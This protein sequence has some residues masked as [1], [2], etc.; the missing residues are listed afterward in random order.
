MRSRACVAAL[1]LML[2]VLCACGQTEEISPTYG[3]EQ[4]YIHTTPEETIPA[5]EP[6]EAYVEVWRE[7]EISRIP[8]EIIHGTVGDYTIAMD[9]EYFTFTAHETVDMFGYDSWPGE[10]PVYFAISRYESAYD[11]AQFAADMLDQ[12][13]AD[14]A[15]WDPDALTVGQYSATALYL[16]SSL[17]APDYNR[18]IFLIDCGGERYLI[19]TE[20]CLEMYE[21]LYPIM[22]A[23]FDTFT[24]G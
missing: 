2:L 24:C 3:T 15:S 21:G 9:P 4:N 20:F 17:D 8:V 11:P 5:T 16:N 14:Y 19:E 7:G 10:Q 23:L 1:F 12:F 6:V 22:R 18:H 13:E